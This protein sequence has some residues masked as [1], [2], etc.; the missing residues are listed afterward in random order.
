MRDLRAISPPVSQGLLGRTHRE[1]DEV[2]G[3]VM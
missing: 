3:A 2:G 1:V